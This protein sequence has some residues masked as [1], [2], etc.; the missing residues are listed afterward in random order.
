MDDMYDKRVCG[1]FSLWPG[2]Q[3]DHHSRRH[4]IS[5]NTLKRLHDWNEK[6][7]KSNDE[8]VQQ[9][10]K[11]GKTVHFA[12]LMDLYHLVDAELARLLQK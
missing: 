11:D 3:A 12:N 1:Q 7:V 5:R 2:T 9:T 4:N 8:V 10:K 6:K